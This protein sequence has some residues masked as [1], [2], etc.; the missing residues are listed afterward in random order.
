MVDPLVLVAWYSFSQGVAFSSVRF[1]RVSALLWLHIFCV[2]SLYVVVCEL[3]VDGYKK[4]YKG[5]ENSA[6]GLP[7][8]ALL[9][10]CIG[11]STCCLSDPACC[12]RDP[13]HGLGHAISKPLV[14]PIVF[15]T[16]TIAD[17]IVAMYLFICNSVLNIYLLG[18]SKMMEKTHRFFGFIMGKQVMSFGHTFLPLL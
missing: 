4:V 10:C 8:N 17:L 7:R 16:N 1:L 9:D 13:N 11:D 15:F 14:C 5:T 2:P 12:L 18:Y 6:I 3:S